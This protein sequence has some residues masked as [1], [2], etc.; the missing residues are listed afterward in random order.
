MAFVFDNPNVEF[1]F[2]KELL[3]LPR[4]SVFAPFHNLE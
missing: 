3:E 1:Y 2:A 4:K